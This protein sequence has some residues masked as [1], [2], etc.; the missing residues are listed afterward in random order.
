MVKQ[1]VTGYSPQADAQKT[2]PIKGTDE[3][4]GQAGSEAL[5]LLQDHGSF[6]RF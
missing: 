2:A 5:S 4:K 1:M 6:A 3:E